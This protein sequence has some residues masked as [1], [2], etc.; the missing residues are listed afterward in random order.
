LIK[1]PNA[2]YP[3]PPFNPAEN[4]PEYPFEGQLSQS[5]NHIYDMVRNLFYIC[6]FDLARHGKPDWNP[7][8]EII[9]PGDK[10]LLKP[11]LVRHFH[12]YKW[13]VLS[14][15]THGSIVRAVLDYVYIA[16]Q[17]K[18]EVVI[19]DSPIQSC[20]FSRV[21]EL[22]GLSEVEKFYADK[23]IMVNVV[24]FR[25]IGTVTNES[26]GHQNVLKKKWLAGDP[27]GYKR[28]NIG[29]QSMLEPVSDS[30]Q[31]FRVT[32]YDPSEMLLHHKQ[33]LHEYII[34]NTV[35]KSDVIINLPKMKT[36]HKAGV[37]GA[38]KNIVGIN[39]SKDWLPHHR[40]GSKQENG[41]EY[42]NKSYWKKIHSWIN[43]KREISGSPA[44]KKITFPVEYVFYRLAKSLAKDK[45]FEG[46]WWGNNTI[47]RT[48]LDLN[49]IM[50]YAD[51]NGNLT[52]SVQ[53]K[54]FS[55]IDGIMAGEG[56]GPLAPT[57][58]KCGLL[59]CGFNSVA[60]DTVISQLMSFDFKKIPQI[61][62]AYGISDYPLVKFSP[63]EIEIGMPD[64][65]SALLDAIPDSYCF[66][67]TPSRGWRGY[68]GN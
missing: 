11:N 19:G 47:W 41:D 65:A 30:P 40:I 58:K 68:L 23:K 46:S 17:G 25:L 8:G 51:K 48:I 27:T 28:V 36:H 29:L 59:L 63:G 42:F 18:G 13:D 54:V 45:F 33:G 57:P 7:L 34:P 38:L 44:F 50:L 10:V 3:L 67:F 24:D 1:N 9:A 12:P 15:V 39:S 52:D 4:Y 22:T 21:K 26:S 37:T 62:N 49:R 5:Q 61:N 32:C 56:D 55:L 53:R 20:D 64:N 14:V 31:K 6:G 35:L 43:D 66:K 16:L 2:D 60:V